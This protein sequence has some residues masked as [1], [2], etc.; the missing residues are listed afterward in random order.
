MDVSKAGFFRT[1]RWLDE[2]AFEALFHEHYPKVYAIVYRL[3]G[4]RD[5]ADDLAAETFW[6]LW[7]HPPARD[8]NLAGWLY[9]VVTRLGYNALRDNRRREQYERAALETTLQDHRSPVQ[10]VEKRFERE[11]VRAVLRHLPFRD[12]Q[13]L[14]LRHSG[15]SYKEIAAA[16]GIRTAS[17]GT[18]LSRAETRFEALYSQGEKDAPEK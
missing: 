2:R 5:A 12:V 10:A 6:R 13:L 1:T 14:I 8:E 9:R 7:D 3:I 16:A 11:R 15:L 18:L 17:V 4:D